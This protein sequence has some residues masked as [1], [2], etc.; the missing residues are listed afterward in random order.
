MT[1]TRTAPVVLAVNDDK[2]VLELLVVL[3]EQEGY[4]VVSASDG[5]RALELAPGLEPDIIISDVVMPEMDG[6]EFCRLLKQDARTSHVPVL[7][8]SAVR[9]SEIDNLHGL[10]AGADDYLEIPFRRQELSVKVAR[11]TE[12]HRVERHYREIVEQAPD[13]IFSRDM[14]GHITSMNEAGACFFGRPASELIGVHLSEL[15]GDKL[16][17]QDIAE[18]NERET[19]E[20]VRQVHLLRDASG[21]PHYLED[22]TTIER[23]ARGLPVGVRGVVRDITEQK[24]AEEALRESEERYRELFENANDIIYTHDL[25]GNFTSLNRTGERVTGYSRE[26]AMR[27]NIAQVVSPDYL[28][29][30]RQMIARK[31]SEDVSTVYEL[32][33]VAKN[34]SRVALEVSTRLIYRNGQ[35]VGVQGIARDITERKRAEG[36]LAQQAVREALINRISSAV[37][38]TLNP[39][40]VFR[41][42]VRE[43]GSHLEVDRCSIF[44]KFPK[45]GIVRNVVEYHAESV[46]PASKDFPLAE[47]SEFINGI[48]Q[49]EVLA[50]DDAA[51]DERISELYHRFLRMAGVRSIMYVAIRVGDE[52]PAAFVLSTTRSARR[53]S[54]SDIQLARAIANHTGLAIRHAELYQ[55][56]EATSV[57]ERLVNRLSLAIRASLSMSEVLETATRELGQALAASRV[58]LRL[59]DSASI[60]SQTSH[61]Y[62]SKGVARV[63]DAVTNYGDPVGQRLLR[64]Q[65]PLVIYDSLNCSVGGQEFNSHV[66]AY[67]ARNSVRSEIL[68]PLVVNDRFRGALCIHQTDRVRHWTED[69]VA[70]VESVAAQLAIGISQAELFE[71][72]KR[73][74]KD[75]ET[76]FNAMSEGIFIFDD[77]GRLARVNRAGAALEDSWPHLLLGRRCCDILRASGDGECLVGKSLGEGRSMTLEVTPERANRP[78]LITVEPVMDAGGKAVG[79]VC[80]ARDLSELRKVE[81]VARERQSLLTHILESV[82][83]PICALDTKGH[84]L[85][86]NT[87]STTT[88]GYR[89]DDLIGH[90]FTEMLHPADREI[91]EKNFQLALGGEPRSYE[92]R[93][94]RRDGEVRD[95]LYYNAPLVID[96]VTTGVLGIARDITEQKQQQQRAAQADKLRALGQLASGVAHDFNNALAAILGRAQLIRRHELNENLSRNLDIIQTAAEDA[97]ATVRRIQTFARKSQENEFELL[98]I[99][100]LLLDAVEITRTR[101]KNEAR[102]RGLQYDVEVEK[103]VA[104]LYTFGN[105]S[106]L[107]EVFVNLIVNAVDAMPA[108]GHLSIGINREG[109]RQCLRFT[110][111]GVGMTD[112]VRE[113]IFEPFY[114]T[115][116]AQG[117]GL[118]LAVSYGIIERHGGLISV[119]SELGH[120]TTF[121]IDLPATEPAQSDSTETEIKTV[122]TPSLRVLV[123][124]DEPTVRDTLA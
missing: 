13:I 37:R 118:G 87:A 65:R 119:K 77:A 103:T 31:T 76:T 55:K 3:L 32:E 26:E 120:G 33:I 123:V 70:L 68:Y 21:V 92:I 25:S 115:K 106:E 20:P 6:L 34:G 72:T 124:D 111:T 56:A 114:T 36:A 24:R 62:V 61:E 38:R 78:L 39:V 52:M 53:W 86:L 40:E 105:A 22:I 1:P 80:T 84:F 93:Y 57:R 99:R 12:R 64:A 109:D 47:L 82:R 89:Q 108:G 49:H 104:P 4:K 19:I 88:T 58:H 85:W 97:A 113:R 60:E 17:E 121:I 95:A 91:A 63:S 14:Q 98:E 81:A 23:D 90:H 116:G 112:E 107:R 67:A 101:W 96:G 45:A 9:T 94:T 48:E 11:L 41:T 16:A 18:V 35:P 59:Y 122:E 74:Q 15:L 102:L 71:I 44:M 51:G 110:D 75:W 42:A 117:T 5:R 66:R 2:R 50:F 54:E 7:L 43:L 10:V 27:M 46:K 100:G 8:V 79:V 29:Q 73:A 30:A 28:E 69:E 83:E